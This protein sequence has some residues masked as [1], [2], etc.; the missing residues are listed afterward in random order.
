M[1]LNNLY[2][3]ESLSELYGAVQS[4]GLLPDSKTFVDA[5]PAYPPAD[6]LTAY[7][8]EKDRSGFDLKTFVDLHFRLPETPDNGYESAQ[9]PIREHLDALWDVLS[10]NPD[11]ATGGTLI[12]LPNPYIVPGG[13]F[14]EI[15][16]WDSYFTML[17][18]RV[19]GRIDLMQNMVDNFA[20]LIEH[21]GFIPNGNRTYY[22]GRSQPPFFAMMVQLL[23]VEYGGIGTLVK[24][25]PQMEREYAFWM[26]G[27]EQL[28]YQ[29]P[30][31]RRVVLMPDGT[32]LNRYWDD[33][34][35]PRPEAFREDVELAQKAGGDPHIVWRH[36]RAAAE[37]GWDFSSRWLRNENDLSSIQTTNLIP[38]DLNCLLY[39]VELTLA[40]AARSID[41]DITDVYTEKAALRLQAMLDYCRDPDSGFFYDYNHQTAQRSDRETLAA[42]FPL[43]F[44]LVD[45]PQSEQL[46]L[47]LER[48]LHAGGVATTLLRSGQQ[49]DA[50]NGWAPLQWMAYKGLYSYGH[51]DLAERIRHNWLNINEKT[52]QETG[53]MMEK[54][55]VMDAGLSAGGGEYPNQDGFGW[56]NGVYLDL[57]TTKDTS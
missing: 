42:V 14:R 15:Y 22:L 52:Y 30:A 48:F 8:Q 47:G 16:Y 9:K 50:P 41:L 19:S 37:S 40:E 28:D 44:G 6:I 21:L 54:Y 23:A 10:R 1:L 18:L 38:V 4:S 57:V 24:Y 56:T 46:A 53:K 5:I 35:T 45:G 32:V 43:F 11:E 26:E 29:A 25:F 3:V 49:W 36:L 31:H 17:G 39:Y 12:P 34:D 2:H 27:T 55:N 51:T 13:R 20:Y 33:L 7:R